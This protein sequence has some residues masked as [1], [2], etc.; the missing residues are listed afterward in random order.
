MVRELGAVCASTAMI[1]TMHYARSPPCSA[2]RGQGHAAPRSPPGAHLSTLALLRDRLAQ[3]L[4]GAAVHRG[5]AEDGGRTVRLDA[6]KSWVTSAG[7]RRQLRLVEPAAAAP[8]T[9]R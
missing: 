7:A 2:A 4:L 9:G 8:P 6:R 3:P 1:V 5:A